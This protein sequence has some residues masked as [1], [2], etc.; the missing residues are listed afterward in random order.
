MIL[1]KST[2]KRLLLIGIVVLLIIGGVYY[3][4]TTQK[5]VFRLTTYQKDSGQ[6]AYR[7]NKKDRI[8]IDQNTIPGFDGETGFSSKEQA[9]EIGNLV[10]DKLNQGTFPPTVTKEE[11]VKH[12]ISIP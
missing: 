8:L 10:I 12:R 11:L 2:K 5:D 3:K 9:T 1:I 6:W 4:L 7:V